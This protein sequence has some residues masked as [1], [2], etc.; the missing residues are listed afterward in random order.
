M[1]NNRAQLLLE[2]INKEFNLNTLK[3]DTKNLLSKASLCS[4]IE[5]LIGNSN[6]DE[7]LILSKALIQL[8]NIGIK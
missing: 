6:R 7:S 8:K 4:V 5:E 1:T 3:E 2:R